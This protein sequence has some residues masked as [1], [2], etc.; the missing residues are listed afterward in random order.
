MVLL[1]CSKINHDT[2]VLVGDESYLKS[3]D[4]IYPEHYREEWPALA[5]G[6]YQYDDNGVM[7]PPIDEG[8]FPP[9]M[10]GDYKID[11]KYITG[12][13]EVIYNGGLIPIPGS[14]RIISLSISNQKNSI[15]KLDFKLNNKSY[16][17][18]NLYIY[19]NADEEDD[20]KGSFTLCFDYSEEYGEIGG[21]SMMNYYGCVIT[22]SVAD[23]AI[24]DSRCW[25]V[26]KNRYPTA[27]TNYS[28]VI[29]G[30][31]FFKSIN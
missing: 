28:Y 4:E 17:I 8:L 9:D 6:Y 2:L 10:N 14:D 23:G 26:I 27:E 15:A 1:A 3:V 31:Q 13:F 12:T 5:P 29:G 11:F 21:V 20:T 22:G 25:I 16:P 18:D 30:Q 7:T 24:Y 19:G